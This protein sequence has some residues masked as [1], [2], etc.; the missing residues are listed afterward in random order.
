[1]TNTIFLKSFKRMCINDS[2]LVDLFNHCVLGDI[3][4]NLHPKSITAATIAVF[5]SFSNIVSLLIGQNAVNT[6]L[7]CY[8]KPMLFKVFFYF[9]ILFEG[10][11][12]ECSTCHG[13][14]RFRGAAR[15]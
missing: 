1:M 6:Q 13:R 2:A 4:V 14:C 8:F 12:N 10:V 15:R 9:L 11:V 7:S 3:S 5:R